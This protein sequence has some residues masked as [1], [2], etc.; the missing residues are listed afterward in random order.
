VAKTGQIGLKGAFY[1]D[2]LN[3]NLV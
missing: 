3:N 2:Y 1:I